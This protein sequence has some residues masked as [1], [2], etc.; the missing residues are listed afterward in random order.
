VPH[1]HR[2]VLTLLVTLLGPATLGVALPAGAAQS[3]VVAPPTHLRPV[4]SKSDCAAV[5]SLAAFVCDAA[6]RTGDLQLIWDE[7]NKTVTG[8]KVYRVDR[9]GHTLLG[10]ATG[11]A[12]YYLV[13]KPSGG[14]TNMCFAVQTYTG[15]RVS[16]D[17]SHYCYAPGATATTRSLKPSHMG[18][19]VSVEY[20]SDQCAPSE[21]YK[22][23]DRDFGS[24]FTTFFPW[25][26]KETRPSQPVDGVYAGTE[27]V[28]WKNPPPCT[29]KMSVPGHHIQNAKIRAWAKVV[30]DLGTLAHS[31]T[32]KV[33]SATLT[34]E[35]LQTVSLTS[36]KATLSRGQ[37]CETWEIWVGTCCPPGPTGRGS[38]TSVNVSG[39][40]QQWIWYGSTSGTEVGAFS[41]MPW[42]HYV[43]GP[44]PSFP[45][46]T[47]VCLTKFSPPSLQLVYF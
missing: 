8:Y 46:G 34:L 11:T 13:N 2:L 33:Y 25:L 29:S 23:A 14:Y 12:R 20:A 31:G 9:G 6:V 40:V 21:V 10:A 7:S 47:Y 27:A 1:P 15:S 19:S 17:S 45:N 43:V 18:T 5:L 41:V 28:S 16:T 39:I 44:S 37:W 35:P 42:L 26:L 24:A 4:Q 36:G 38:G 22:S 30:F 32:H 3:T